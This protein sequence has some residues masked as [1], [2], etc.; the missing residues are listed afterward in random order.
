MEH[1]TIGSTWD[2]AKDEGKH[3]KNILATG[4]EVIYNFNHSFVNSIKMYSQYTKFTSGLKTKS[5]QT[6]NRTH[7]AFKDI[8]QDGFFVGIDFDITPF[9]FQKIKLG[10]VY[11]LFDR[12]DYRAHIY[13]VGQVDETEGKEGP[14]CLKDYINSKQKSFIVNAH[15]FFN[16]NI[17]LT[18]GAHFLKDPLYWISD[19]LKSRGSNTYNLS[20]NVPF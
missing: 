9:I 12:Y 1:G 20:L 8:V 18:I 13:S 10:F 7:L 14:E 6:K 11:E 16:K 4:F 17:Y 5:S 2:I 15:F 19:V 3:N